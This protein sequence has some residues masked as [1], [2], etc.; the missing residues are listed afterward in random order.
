MKSQIA[1]SKRCR[2]S[3]ECFSES[4]YAVEQIL[5]SVGKGTFFR[6]PCSVK[7]SCN[8]LNQ[9][10]KCNFKNFSNRV[11][12]FSQLYVISGAIKSVGTKSSMAH[13]SDNLESYYYVCSAEHYSIRH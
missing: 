8:S 13:S 6:N 1:P 2:D 5:K 7:N 9:Y 3:K 10:Q 4:S 11:T 12:K